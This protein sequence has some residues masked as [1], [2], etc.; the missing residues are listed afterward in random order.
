ML[1]PSEL[2]DFL[3][4]AAR[5]IADARQIDLRLWNNGS[6]RP[7]PTI[8]EAATLIYIN[9][10]VK[11][12]RNAL[13]SHANLTTTVSTLANIREWAIKRKKHVICFVTG[14]PGSGKT[15][16]GLDLAHDERFSSTQCGDAAFLSGNSPLI[17]VLREALA[18][19]AARKNGSTLEYEKK[20]VRTRIQHLMN[21]LGQYLSNKA[22]DP[23]HEHVVVFDEAQ[24]AWDQAYGKQKF[25]RTASEPFLFLEIMARH[26]DWAMIV[27]L[28]GGGQEINRGEHGLIEWGK[29]IIEFNSQGV[30]RWTVAAN[31]DTIGGRALYGGT[32]LWNPKDANNVEKKNND[33]LH[34]AVSVRSHRNEACSEWIAAVVDG[35]QADAQRI[36]KQAGLWD[37]PIYITR[38]IATARA[39]LRNTSLGQ[40]RCGLLATSGARR[41]RAYGLGASLKV[42]ELQE[43][44]Q[45]FLA[46]P[47]DLRSSNALEVTA[48][49]FACQGLEIDRAC[50]CWDHDLTWDRTTS[51]WAAKSFQGSAWKGV[52]DEAKRRY[53]ANSYRVLLS[54]AR[55]AFVIWVPPG[56]AGDGTRPPIEMDMTYEY[57]S[58]CG[59]RELGARN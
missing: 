31:A 40:R 42:T 32:P 10:S 8:I 54:R 41:L 28:V 26:A 16:I 19:G 5:S 9:H 46:D 18:R 20:T 53:I 1:V 25:D 2:S 6:Y 50:L 51:R 34:L 12:I 29:A 49:E 43:I 22:A 14:V 57:L 7:V 15:L 27:A 24:R 56:D 37:F 13:S 39:W 3:V 4:E 36:A 59:V 44:V 58:S 33:K 48:T 30:R 21:Y 38:S 11:E 52:R 47:D 35:R 45:W 23:P 17:A 55:E